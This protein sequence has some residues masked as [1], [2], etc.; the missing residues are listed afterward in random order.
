MHRNR[1]YF[2]RTGDCPDRPEPL[3]GVVDA[4]SAHL[5]WYPERPGAS[6]GDVRGAGLS[7]RCLTSALLLFSS[8][9]CEC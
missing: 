6:T 9:R 1:R 8:A 2:I 7:H 5:R 4:V 3:P